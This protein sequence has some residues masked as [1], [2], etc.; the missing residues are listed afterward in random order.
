[1]KAKTFKEVG[2]FILQADNKK[3]QFIHHYRDWNR[4][5]FKEGKKGFY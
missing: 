2:K 5:I 4:S 3:L 1:M